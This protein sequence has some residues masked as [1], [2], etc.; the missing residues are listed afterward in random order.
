[1]RAG[2]KLGQRNIEHGPAG[3]NHGALKKILQL[4]DI[5]RPVPANQRL[6]RLFGDGL[7]GLAHAPAMSGYKM[8]H[9]Y[10]NVAGPVAQR[11]SED[12]KDL[13][14]GKRDRC[15]TASPQPSAPGRDWWRQSGEH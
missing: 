2:F 12:G 13:Q 1:M 9:Q 7:D 3:E 5:A 14:A 11:R 15:E 6:H 8:T 10:G 4:A